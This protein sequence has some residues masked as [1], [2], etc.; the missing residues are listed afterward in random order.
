[1]SNKTKQKLGLVLV[2]TAAVDVVGGEGTCR[3]DHHWDNW[4]F[5]TAVV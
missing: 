5:L 3:E 1:L 4:N 2:A